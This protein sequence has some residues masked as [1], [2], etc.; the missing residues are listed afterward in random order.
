MCGNEVGSY[1]A[2]NILFDVKFSP[3]QNHLIL[4]SRDKTVSIIDWRTGSLI[5]TLLGHADSCYGIDVLPERGLILSA[6]LDNTIKVW[7][8]KT[9]VE[10]N[11][12]ITTGYLLDRTLTGHEVRAR[13]LLTMPC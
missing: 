2:N 8:W 7:C 13:L 9:I 5:E 4:A 11:G 6:S 1:V 3:D 12:P 10:G